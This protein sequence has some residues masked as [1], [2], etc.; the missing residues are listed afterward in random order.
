M[1][2]SLCCDLGG[3]IAIF[4]GVMRPVWSLCFCRLL[5]FL[6]CELRCIYDP[7]FFRMVFCFFVC[8]FAWDM[9]V[10]WRLYA[11]LW[12]LGCRLLGGL[13]NDTAQV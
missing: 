8:V 5:R 6:L 13:S 1:W 2:L 4:L 3:C 10:V 11:E 9:F 12:L 7:V